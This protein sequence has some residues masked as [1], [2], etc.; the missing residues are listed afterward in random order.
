MK[1]IGDCIATN[2][3]KILYISIIN[4]YYVSINLNEFIFFYQCNP[5]Y[6]KHQ[7]ILFTHTRL[8]Y[9]L[10]TDI[11][12]CISGSAECHDNATCANTDGSYECT[13]DTG[14]TGDGINCTSEI[15]VCILFP[16]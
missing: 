8:F 1:K 9:T 7:L 16:P 6:S 14:F 3:R 11:N 10:S 2:G 13:C 4:T 5:S 12:E 15:K